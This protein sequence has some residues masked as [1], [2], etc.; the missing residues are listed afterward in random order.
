VKCQN[1]TNSFYGVWELHWEQGGRRDHNVTHVQEIGVVTDFQRTVV[2]P[3]IP[4][5][6]LDVQCR[7]FPIQQRQVL[8][9][10][11]SLPIAFLP[12]KIDH[13][14]DLLGFR[15]GKLVKLIPSVTLFAGA[16]ENENLQNECDCDDDAD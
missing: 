2:E 8:V 9:D 15:F 6:V 1:K 14:R 11:E 7:V 4:I 3:P 13:F 12:L 10:L 16:R 5:P